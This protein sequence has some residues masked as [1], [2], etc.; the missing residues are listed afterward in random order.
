[1]VKD[2]L[3]ENGKIIIKN[4]KKKVILKRKLRSCFLYKTLIARL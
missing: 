2:F 3:V 4:A 1:M